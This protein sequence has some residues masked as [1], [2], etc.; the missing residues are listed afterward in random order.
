MC[1]NLVQSSNASIKLE[2]NTLLAPIL[3][4]NT[5]M[6]KINMTMISPNINNDQ[7]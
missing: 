6:F 7:N 5:N 1:Y 2:N 3:Y 4:P